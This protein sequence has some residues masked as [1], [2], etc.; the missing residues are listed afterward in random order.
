VHNLG[1]VT[2]GGGLASAAL[3]LFPQDHPMLKRFLCAAALVPML[4]GSAF[5]AAVQPVAPDTDPVVARVNGEEI[6]RS[7]INAIMAQLPA[8]IQEMPIEQ[9]LPALIDRVINQKLIAA[10]GYQAKLQDTPQ[11]KDD[12]KQAE[13]RAVSRAYL[14]KLVDEKV[15]PSMLENA[16]KQELATNP[17]QEEVKAAH[18][19]VETEAEAK[20]I[21]AQLQKG[22][23][24]AKLAKEKS[25][26]PSAAAQGG[27]L[28]YFSKDKMVPE[29]ADAAFAMK[30][31]EVSKAPVKTQFGWHVIKVEDRRTPTA[32]TLDEMK[33]E[34]E[35]QLSQSII[36]H[37]IETLRAAAKIEVLTPPA[38]PAPAPAPA[39][40]K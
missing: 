7:Q 10:A 26:D 16:Y 12:I 25:K 31:G 5:A 37:E 34:L 38:A 27:D 33:P 8:N 9:V 40:S 3:F 24:F 14:T 35:Q 13:E 21:I 39:P 29:F 20:D 4:A 32:P 15:T 17:P 28:G 36:S 1:I 30:P 18:I 23:D 22:G 19:L 11:V 2:A 6:H